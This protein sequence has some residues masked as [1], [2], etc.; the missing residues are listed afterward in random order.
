MLISTLSALSNSASTSGLITKDAFNIVGKTAIEYK[1]TG[2]K[3]KNLAK[4]AASERLREEVGTSLIWLGGLP[5]VKKIYDKIVIQKI[6][7]LNSEID[8]DL[9]TAK[10]VQSLENNKVRLEKLASKDAKDMAKTLG[11][12]IE[13]KQL[14]KNLAWG[15]IV[16]STVLVLGALLAFPKANYAYTKKNMEKEA[17]AKKLNSDVRTESSSVLGKS[18]AFAA[19]IDKT[20]KG[21]SFT[22]GSLMHWLANPV[23]NTMVLDGGISTGRM[24]ASATRSKAEFVETTAKEGLFVYFCYQAGKHIR[25]AL[26]TGFKAIGTPVS[27]P[28]EVLSN[29]EMVGKLNSIN[30]PPKIQENLAEYLKLSKIKI[31]SQQDTDAMAKL[32]EIIINGID[33][34]IAKG[35]KDKALSFVEVAQKAKLIDITSGF[36]NPYK[37]VDIKE[38]ALLSQSVEHFTSAASKSGKS[39]ENLAKTALKGKGFSVVADI[40]ICSAALG[41]V[42]PKIGVAIRKAMTGSTV[43]PGVNQYND[44]ICLQKEQ[45][46]A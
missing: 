21:L 25:N 43:S 40:A 27:L 24:G 15:R 44:Q 16:A 41:Y 45:Q 38:L 4:H 10:G 6:A 14:Y 13:H 32:E 3:D 20:K 34:H 28:F 18:P 12:V 46:K 31:K 39:L 29:K 36:R 1:E 37:K 9:L 23:N 2:K 5:F 26:A 11:N 35:A 22:G 19:F 17:A 42:I 7:K 33:G 30:H 8:Y